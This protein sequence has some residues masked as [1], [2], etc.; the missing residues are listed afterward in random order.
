MVPD[1]FLVPFK[2]N[3]GLYAVRVSATDITKTTGTVKIDAKKKGHFYHMG[4]W[5]D[6]NGDGR[7]DYITARSNAKKGGGELLWFEHPKGG[8]DSG[9]SWVEHS[10]GNLADVAF[11]VNTLPEYK[12][13]IVVFSAH[14]FDEAIRMTRIS[15]VDGS[16]VATKTIDDKNILSAYNVAMVDL[17]SDGNRQILVNN[18][19]TKSKKAG[20]WAYEFPKDLMNDDWSRQTIANDFKNAWS[21]TVPNMSPG[22]AYAVYPNG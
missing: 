16:L 22:F 5:V 3:G 18:H 9:S 19:E 21:L 10:L 14:F 2:K 13:E 1:G 6:L 7:K 17:N 20:I 4:Y 11:E 8:L 15:T 12:D